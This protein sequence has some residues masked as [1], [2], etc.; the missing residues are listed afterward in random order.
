MAAP[1][2]KVLVIDDSFMI[3]KALIDQLSGARFEVFAARDG[4]TGLAEATQRNPDVILLDFLMPDLNG[5][6]V[7]QALRQQPQ[8]ACTPIILISSSRDEVVR[9]FGEPFKGFSF[10]P[11]P[12]T[13]RQIE[14][15]LA[16]VLSTPDEPDLAPP[17]A[18]VHSL[19]P[20]PVTRPLPPKEPATAANDR[21]EAALATLLKRLDSLERQSNAS[22]YL[23]ILLLILNTALLLTLLLR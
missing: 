20:V 17:P 7:Y 5:Y 15:Q 13:R 12:F 9:K 18:A 21:M 14:E 2:F 22:R 4:R 11:K 10:L 6:E 3:R 8:F 19:P 23:P 16:A 1:K